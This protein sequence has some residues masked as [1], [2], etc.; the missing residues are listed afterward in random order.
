MS[1]APLYG[2]RTSRTAAAPR[3]LLLYRSFPRFAS[4]GFRVCV[5]I[6]VWSLPTAAFAAER[7]FTAE[8]NAAYVRKWVNARPRAQ[9]A[10]PQVRNTFVSAPQDR[11]WPPAVH[12]HCP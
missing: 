8:H 5:L 10:P 7:D 6:A 12:A 11:P 9:C 4:G 1:A 2:S 3:Q